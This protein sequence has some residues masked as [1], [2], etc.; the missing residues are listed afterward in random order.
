MA[1]RYEERAE[2]LASL[3]A[4]EGLDLLL[5]TSPIG[6]EYLTGF[7]GSNGACLIGQGSRR[8]LTDFR[9]EERMSGG[10]PGWDVEIP[11]G[12]WS[13]ELAS[14]LGPRT[15][16]EDDHLT[17]RAA[18]RLEAEAGSGVEL[19]AAGGL[20]QGLRR[21]KD[22][23]EIAAIARAAELSDAIL[24]EVF[25]AGLAG[26][27]EADVA[28]QI[29]G[30]MREEGAEP[31]FL[32]IV[33]SGPNGA[34]PHAE[35]GPRV[36]AGGE[37]VVIDMGARLEGYCSDCTRTVATGEVSEQARR[38]HSVVL[39]ANE[40]ALAEV[41]AGA[42]CV[43]VDLAARSVIEEAGWGDRFG[44][45]VGHGVG[46]EIHEAPRLGPRS[47]DTLVERDVVTVEPGVY[48]P[49][50]LGVRIE[51]LVVVGSEGVHL[52]L[53]SHPK[54]LLVID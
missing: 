29:V 11:R 37:L 10:L 4:E 26:R 12:D 35:P 25:E 41:V 22:E 17:V 5:V 43:E 38:A 50:S 16:I 45:G 13:H 7:T 44:H 2:R 31:S 51:D 46:L 3:V 39:E 48:L 34:D 32:P 19:V 15:G 28:G 14:R 42:L 54:D 53:S 36:I 21:S 33:A 1:D 6:L 24:M 52:N 27:T 23:D 18:N 40:A 9:Y 30:R 47:T 20:I 49:G 8:F